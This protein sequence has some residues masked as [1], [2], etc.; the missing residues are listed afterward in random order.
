VVKLLYPTIEKTS[1]VIRILESCSIHYTYQINYSKFR[2]FHYH[3]VPFNMS[4]LFVMLS[5][6]NT[7]VSTVNQVI[8]KAYF[9]ICNLKSLKAVSSDIRFHLLCIDFINLT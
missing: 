4:I 3:L 1:L 8:L 2:F 9:W 7:Y 5:L 6:I